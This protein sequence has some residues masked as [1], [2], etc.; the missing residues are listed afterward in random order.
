LAAF[1]QLGLAVLA[2]ADDQRGPCRFDDVVGDG[3]QF[4]DFHDPFY[5]GEETVMRRKLPG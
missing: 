5:L 4:I 1:S 3:A 2:D